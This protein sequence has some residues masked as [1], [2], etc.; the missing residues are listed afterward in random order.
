[1]R[2]I[3]YKIFDMTEKIICTVY[4]LEWAD[5]NLWADCIPH[6]KNVTR[7]VLDTAKNPLLQFT[8]LL[9]KSGKEVYEGDIIQDTHAVKNETYKSKPMRVFWN[10]ENCAFEIEPT[11]PYGSE[12]I[13]NIY[14]PPELYP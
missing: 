2:E 12:V 6:L 8:G 7:R 13:G 5:G 14:E 4:R 1:M 11:I 10:K 9:D 3:K